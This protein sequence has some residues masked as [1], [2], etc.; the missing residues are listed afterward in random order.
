MEMGSKKSIGSIEPQNE[1]YTCPSCGYEDGFH[2]S[3]KFK[4]RKTGGEIYLICPSC[5]SRF[6]IGWT[7]EIKRT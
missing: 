1:V 6:R 3:F 2:V 5:H 4:G 7:V